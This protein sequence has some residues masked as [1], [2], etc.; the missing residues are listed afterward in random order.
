M[1]WVPVSCFDRDV[2]VGD[3]VVNYEKPIP[4]VDH[5][6]C[7]LVLGVLK[8]DFVVEYNDELKQIYPKSNGWQVWR[9]TNRW[10][11]EPMEE[12]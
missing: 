4:P 3:R 9:E 1:T 8:N 5:N 7:A 10:K 2:K 11:P 12:K 6:R